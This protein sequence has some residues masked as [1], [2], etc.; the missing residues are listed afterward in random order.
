MFPGNW[1]NYLGV[2]EFL[3]YE[4]KSKLEDYTIFYSTGRERRRKGE[5]EIE[6]IQRL[7]S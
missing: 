5:G 1:S 2:M 6:V 3:S 4:T 7:F